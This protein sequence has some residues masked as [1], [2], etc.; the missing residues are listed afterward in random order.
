MPKGSP[1]GGDALRLPFRHSSVWARVN[2]VQGS[3]AF[4]D[5]RRRTPGDRHSRAFPVNDVGGV[6][7]AIVFAVV[8]WRAVV[9]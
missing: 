1:R 9:A 3:S 8:A 7:L 5:G 6:V 2:Q 4:L